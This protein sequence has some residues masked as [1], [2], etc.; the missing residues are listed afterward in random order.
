M[1][2][3][4]RTCSA[5]HIRKSTERM[6]EWTTWK[7]MHLTSTTIRK[8]SSRKTVLLVMCNIITVCIMVVQWKICCE[9]ANGFKRFYILMWVYYHDQHQ[10]IILQSCNETWDNEMTFSL[11]FVQWLTSFQEKSLLERFDNE[12]SKKLQGVCSIPRCCCIRPQE[13]RVNDN[14]YCKLELSRGNFNLWT[15]YYTSYG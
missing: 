11:S 8:S 10:N 7:T 6:N 1:K 2:L 14:N 12:Y 3:R 9:L 13:L 15:R 5:L 4:S